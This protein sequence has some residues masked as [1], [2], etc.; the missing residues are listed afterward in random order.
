MST[1]TRI[2]IPLSEEEK[3]SPVAKFYDPQLAPL[4]QKLMDILLAGPMDAADMIGPEDAA[5]LLK[6]GYV[7]GE[8]GYGNLKTGGGYVAV[9]NQFPG[10]TLD[11][12]K[13]WFAWHPL[14]PLRYKIWDPYCHPHAEVS[15]EDRAKIKNPDLPVEEKI[16]H[17]THTLVEDI[18]SGMQDIII[19][20]MPVE[21]LGFTKEALAAAHA[22]AIGGVA[23]V[24]DRG[25]DAP[26]VPVIMLH[27]YRETPDGI[28]SRTRFWMG[29]SIVDGK[30]RFMLP[31]G[32]Q[33]P[34]A[35]ARG[36]ALHNVEEYSNL[37][38]V[39]PLVYKEFGAL[40][41]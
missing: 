1:E 24:G 34:L 39:L 10:V 2:P 31:E 12:I 22:Y 6:A 14:E 19:H 25:V 35:V 29:Y 36:L 18:G 38:K 26:K 5:S 17:V 7:K 28:E 16:I 9:N 15:E 41:L 3:K 13:W 27:Y 4:N 30:A 23:L 40:P 11:M 8:T 21:A 37:G 32:M 20:F 33:V